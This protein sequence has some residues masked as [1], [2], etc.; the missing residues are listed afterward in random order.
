MVDKSLIKSAIEGKRIIIKCRPKNISRPTTQDKKF[1][2]SF[3]D[4]GE[5]D[6]D[7]YFTNSYDDLEN[8]QYN[9]DYDEI[10]KDVVLTDDEENAIGS[11][12]GQ[13]YININYYAYEHNKAGFNSNGAWS[14]KELD[15]L[16]EK[17]ETLKNVIDKTPNNNRD[18]HMFRIGYEPFDK[19]E[20]GEVYT[21]EGFASLTYSESYVDNNIEYINDDMQ[22]MLDNGDIEKDDVYTPFK[23]DYYVPT[24]T[25]GLYV[26]KDYEDEYLTGPGTRYYCFDKDI[27]KYTAKVVILP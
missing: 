20:V 1:L 24:D 12:S 19:L 5:A 18:M 9:K 22:E 16:K 15:N 7:N 13:E 23:I 6:M 14:Q 17:Y 27:N 2:S 10:M 3:G 21:Q 8:V 4:D 25:H 26:A 11:W